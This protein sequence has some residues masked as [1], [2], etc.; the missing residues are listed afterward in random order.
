MINILI[1]EDD[2][3][4]R[5]LFNSVI[6]D[7]G[8]D[9]YLAKDG[10]EAFDIL[11][12]NDIDLIISD[13]MMPRMDGFEMVENLRDSGYTMPVLMITAKDSLADKQKGFR[14][15]TDDYMVKPIDVNEMIW[16][17]EALLRRSNIMKK[18]IVK[19]GDTE[20]NKDTLVVVSN[21]ENIELTQKEFN[22]LFQ[23]VSSPNK[24]YTRRK[25]MDIVWGV[26]TYS[27][28]HTLDV[29][30]SKLRV[31]FKDNT[32]FKIVTIKGLGYKVVENEKI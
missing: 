5:K 11:D 7:N 18:N 1:V 9:T 25:L 10:I 28:E 30:I 8:Y 6:R 21:G 29:H 15:G 19:M 20:F 3:Q 32:D 24:V 12:D 14:V 27:D 23:L 16:R 2:E 4:L 13:V 31:K 22:L 17:V 26:D